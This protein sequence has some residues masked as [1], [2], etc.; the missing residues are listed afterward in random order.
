MHMVGEFVIEPDETGL[1][2]QSNAE[3][4]RDPIDDLDHERHDVVGTAVRV[5]LN[6]VGVLVRHRRATDAEPF[7]AGYI[8][9]HYYA[10]ASKA[11]ILKPAAL[12]VPGEKFSEAFGEE[13]ETVKNEEP[14]YSPEKALIAA[15]EALDDE[16]FKP[17]LEAAV[18][19]GRCLKGLNLEGRHLEGADLRKAR[20]HRAKA[21]KVFLFDTDLEGAF[22]N[23][24]MESGLGGLKGHRSVGGCRAS[25]YNAMPHAGVTAL[26]EFMI[27][28][29]ENHPG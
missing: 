18:R 11:T 26:A 3:R 23:E 28:F 13:W 7:E 4:F 29:Q 27:A 6:E 1:G 16:A 20:L 24:A 19:A 2:M 9:Q 15:L 12:N 22:L 25:I 8:D 5:C 21:E 10:I 17:A 14:W